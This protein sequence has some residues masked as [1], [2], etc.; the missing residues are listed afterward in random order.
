MQKEQ[1]HFNTA[2]L[3]RQ[4]WSII[5]YCMAKKKTFSW[6]NN[7]GINPKWGQDVPILAA[8]VAS[9]STGHA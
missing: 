9:Q 5:I 6:G 2:I 4:A 8:W 7:A 1:G 3:T